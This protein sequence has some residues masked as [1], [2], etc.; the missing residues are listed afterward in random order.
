MFINCHHQVNAPFLMN[1]GKS[2]YK[3]WLE[4]G[5]RL[6]KIVRNMSK[7]HANIE[8]EATGSLLQ[9]AAGLIKSSV[10]HGFVE[11]DAGYANLINALEILK[12]KGIEVILKVSIKSLQTNVCCISFKFLFYFFV[13]LL[14]LLQMRSLFRS[15]PP[16]SDTLYQS[17]GSF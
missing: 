17:P 7:G 16:C 6:A 9:D 15:C 8:I 5:K 13:S 4:L 2:E 3:C 14:I 11:E 10:A 1:M 12:G